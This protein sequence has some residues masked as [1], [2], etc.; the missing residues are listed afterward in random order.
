MRLHFSGNAK[1]KRK[2]RKFNLTFF[3]QRWSKDIFHKGT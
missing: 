2:M 3:I 1:G